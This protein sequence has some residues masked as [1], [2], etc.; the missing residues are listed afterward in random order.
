MD[1]VVGSNTL[2]KLVGN[3]VI[4]V[5]IQD[6]TEPNKEYLDNLYNVLDENQ[7][8]DIYILS[9]LITAE[10][11][12]EP[13]IGQ[14]AVGSVVMNRMKHDNQ[15]MQQVIFRKNAF[16][17]VKNGKINRTPTQQCRYAAI[18]AYFG[19]KPVSNARFF[20]G[21]HLTTSWAALHCTLYTIIGNHAFYI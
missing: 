20:N 13:Y 7:K 19:A 10:S 17:V 15:T 11:G 5:F 2:M 3:T 1:G 14:V 8:Q 4:D 16:S 18:Q 12:Y 9:Q 21:K 6:C